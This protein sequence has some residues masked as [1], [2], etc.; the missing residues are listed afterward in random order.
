VLALLRGGEAPLAI[1]GRFG[2]EVDDLFDWL[3]RYRERG[4]G[5]L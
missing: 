5:G 4:R 1:A 2:V 3:E